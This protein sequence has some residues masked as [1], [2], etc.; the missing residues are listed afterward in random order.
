MRIVQLTKLNFLFLFFSHFAQSISTHNQVRQ[1]LKNKPLSYYLPYL[2]FAWANTE[3]ARLFAV[4]LELLLC[5]TFEA[6]VAS[7]ELDVFRELDFAIG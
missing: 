7:L 3:P 6:F 4:L 1:N 2:A 5:S